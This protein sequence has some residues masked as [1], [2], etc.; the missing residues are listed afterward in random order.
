MD[1]T[2]NV[3][4]II[5]YNIHTILLFSLL[6]F[7]YMLHNK[8]ILTVIFVTKKNYQQSII[9]PYLYKYIYKLNFWFKI[10]I[11]NF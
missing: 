1:P 10:D 7:K 4:Y 5:L 3:I 9:W 11:R 8:L 2:K 6:V